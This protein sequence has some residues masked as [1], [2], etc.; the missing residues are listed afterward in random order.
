MDKITRKQ[1]DTFGFSIVLRDSNGVLLDLEVTDIQSQVRKKNTELVQDLSISKISTG[2]FK[3]YTTNTT[4]YPVGQLEID[5][6]GTDGTESFS[7]DTIILDML[8]AVT[9]WK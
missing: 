3:I 5:V 8:K 7:T 1:G 2:T 4:M 6:R 9:V